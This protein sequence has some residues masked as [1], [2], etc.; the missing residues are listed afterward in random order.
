MAGDIYGYVGILTDITE[1]KKQEAEL[2]PSG[3]AALDD[4]CAEWDGAQSSAGRWSRVNRAL[5]EM[6]GFT[7]AALLATDF[8][9]LTHPE[10][11]AKD[12]ALV[13]CARG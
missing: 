10:D 2:R 8:Q 9:S 11:L 4:R 12:L 13:A 3:S 5:L 7:E 6:L 1:Q